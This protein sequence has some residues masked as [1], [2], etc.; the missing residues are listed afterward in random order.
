[1]NLTYTHQIRNINPPGQCKAALRSA[2]CDSSR[3]SSHHKAVRVYLNLP[4][5]TLL[6]GP[7]R[8]HIRVYNTN[9]LTSR[10]W[11][12]KVGFSGSGR[13]RQFVDS[14]LLASAM[15]YDAMNE[16]WCCRTSPH[17][18]RRREHTQ[19]RDNKKKHARPSANSHS[20]DAIGFSSVFVVSSR[21]ERPS[22]SPDTAGGVQF[23][24]ER[25]ASV[26]GMIQKL[27]TL[28]LPSPRSRPV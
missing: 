13:R 12:V 17:K 18:C 3:C 6:Q 19:R 23:R 5:A 4:K 10:V 22:A 15:S 21:L 25:R 20:L 8:F 24:R 9:L 1:M 27:R 7:A 26:A 11:Y 28:R 14:P 16:A 2:I